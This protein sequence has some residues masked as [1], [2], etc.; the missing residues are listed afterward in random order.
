MI[1]DRSMFGLGPRK[2]RVKRS[3]EWPRYRKAW[4]AQHPSCAACGSAKKLTVHHKIPVHWDASR[5]LDQT[6]YITLC[7]QGDHNDHLL[8]GHLLDWKSKNDN[9]EADTANILKEIEARPYP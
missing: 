7:E 1:G 5:E 9:V 2:P 3:P 6:N 4:L 8:F